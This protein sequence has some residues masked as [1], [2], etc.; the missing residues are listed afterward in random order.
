[1]LPVGVEFEGYVVDTTLGRGG[2]A[3]VYRAHTA[4]EPN[5]PV[6]LKVLDEH[7][8]GEDQTAKLRKEF[9]FAH[10]LDLSLIHI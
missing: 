1:M 2:Y 3:A 7:H 4:A 8:R 6:A 9:D 5:R 10:Q